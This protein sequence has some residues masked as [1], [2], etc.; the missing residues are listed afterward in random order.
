MASGTILLSVISII[1]GRKFNITVKNHII[2]VEKEKDLGHMN[3][4]TIL[5]LNQLQSDN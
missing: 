4:T 1:N 5:Y 2:M 3:I